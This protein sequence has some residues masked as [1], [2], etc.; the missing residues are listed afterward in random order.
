VPSRARMFEAKVLDEEVT[1]SMS[2]HCLRVQVEI[3]PFLLMFL[4]SDLVSIF[5]GQSG[6]R[7]ESFD[8]AYM[9]RQALSAFLLGNPSPTL[10]DDEGVAS[11]ST[12][13]Q[14][15]IKL[16]LEG[17]SLAPCRRCTK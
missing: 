6:V 8:A 17:M 7:F 16:C 14:R 4:A 11:T 3:A 9:S 12:S 1:A 10:R 15:H 13:M 5:I 2:A